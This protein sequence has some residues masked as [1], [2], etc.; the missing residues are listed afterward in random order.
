M[1]LSLAFVSAGGG[2]AG[3]GRGGAV[4]GWGVGG[5]VGPQG[6]LR[7]QFGLWNNGPRGLARQIYESLYTKESANMA[8]FSEGF[9]I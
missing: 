8:N 6:T 4:E 3:H 1:R 2:S 9:R 7:V 5:A